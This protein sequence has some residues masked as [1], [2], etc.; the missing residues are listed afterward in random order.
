[1]RHMGL[2]PISISS[3]GCWC[4]VILC[5]LLM[6]LFRINQLYAADNAT[7]NLPVS[8]ESE[9]VLNSDIPADVTLPIINDA[10][11]GTAARIGPYTTRAYS[12][13][14][15]AEPIDLN[16]SVNHSSGSQAYLQK[17]D[18]SSYPSVPFDQKNIPYSVIYQPCYNSSQPK[19]AEM[20]LAIGSNQIT[21]ASA[22][23]A[24]CLTAGYNPPGVPGE[25]YIERDSMS[26]LPLKGDYT[27]TI[28]L[29]IGPA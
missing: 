19:P 17:T 9:F 11:K 3:A 7:V 8:V 26:V 12:N 10:N 1:M 18:A 14:P 27:G 23:A 28:T 25:L 13:I 5:V 4:V 2:I 22:N 6:F 21:A 24:S 29:T 15:T 20:T 16:L